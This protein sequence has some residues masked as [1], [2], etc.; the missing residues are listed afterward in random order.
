MPSEVR[1]WQV[2]EAE[3]PVVVPRL[4]LDLEKRLQDW[5]AVD[6]SVLDPGLLVIGREVPT[7]FGDFIDLLCIDPAGDLVVVELKRD[8]TP[9]E[10]MAQALDYASW[11]VDLSN[12]RVT[13]IANAY[14]AGR[15]ED[16]FRGRFG[17]EVPETVNGDHRILVV[18]SEI[19]ERSE[20]IIRY[21]S[22]AHGVNINAA[23][24]EYFRLADGAELIARVFLIEPS[25]VEQRTRTKGV[26]KRRNYLSYEE[27]SALATDAGVRE[28]YDHAVESFE[29]L[30]KKNRT[31]SSVGF[32]G[33]FAGSQKQVVSFIPGESDTERGLRYQLY[34]H[35]FADLAGLEVG[36]LDA[37]LP[38]TRDFWEYTKNTEPDYQGFTGFI[39]DRSEIDRLAH[40]LR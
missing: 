10:V 24:F 20:R 34:K 15:F 39:R 35:R 29:P 4:R 9:R 27:L 23:T 6:I 7:D 30:L 36:D 19:D 2:G 32:A 18:G 12:E 17:S 16:E 31:L 33:L 13:S 25:E 26:S 8:K 5:L 3:Q 14:L 22:Q 37:L 11:V 40:A 38:A 21:L 1:L 28:L